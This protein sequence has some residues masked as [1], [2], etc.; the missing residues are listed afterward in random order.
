MT[1]FDS[2][3][4]ET[5]QPTSDDNDYLFDS[6]NQKLEIGNLRATGRSGSFI[7]GEDYAQYANLSQYAQ[8]QST[9][10]TSKF[11]QSQNAFKSAKKLQF[12][13]DVHIAGFTT[14]EQ[15]KFGLL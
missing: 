14:T 1:S 7:E 5:D 6:L 15:P 3:S 12:G 8:Q 10:T 4:S 11:A 2:S 13:E 9:A